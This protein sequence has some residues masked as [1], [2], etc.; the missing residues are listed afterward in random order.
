MVFGSPR[1]Q[2][3]A[4][5]SYIGKKV[6]ASTSGFAVAVFFFLT[7]LPA[8]PPPPP[9]FHQSGL[10]PAT[11]AGVREPGPNFPRAP[12]AVQSAVL[13]S[14]PRIS[15]RQ[16]TTVAAIASK[17]I[18][19]QP[20]PDLKASCGSIAIS[21]SDLVPLLLHID[22]GPGLREF[23]PRKAAWKSCPENVLGG[24]DFL[25][26]HLNSLKPDSTLK[27][28]GMQSLEQQRKVTIPSIDGAVVRPF[29]ALAKFIVHYL[30]K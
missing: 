22:S 4:S 30:C 18:L 5:Q 3:A 12:G 25:S 9:G 15:A 8:P 21:D 6:H 11:P 29:L 13:K 19:L 28:F 1:H 14:P 17:L 2:D 26:C 24:G 10:D 23:Q 16:P 27:E 20:P 7:S